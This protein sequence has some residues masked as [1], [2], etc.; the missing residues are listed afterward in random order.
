[1]RSKMINMVAL[2]SG[3]LVCCLLVGP[4]K[5]AAVTQNGGF[6]LRGGW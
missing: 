3:E 4:A 5:S 2:L 6:W 1:M